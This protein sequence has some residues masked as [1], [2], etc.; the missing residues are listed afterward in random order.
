MITAINMARIYSRKAGKS[1]SKK[2]PV[3]FVQP[4]MKYKKKDVE[5]LIIKLSKERKGSAAIGTILRD[6]YGIPDV[7]RITGK[8]IVRIMQENRLYQEL[9]EDLL[10]LFRMAVN[11]REHLKKNKA[12]KHSQKGLEH[13]ESKIRRLVKYYAGEGKIPAG[14]EYDPDKVKLIVQK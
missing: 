2:P 14:F 7:K 1:G 12:D 8:T 4:W 5:D 11:L 3:K 6:Q 10:S 9:P 13:L